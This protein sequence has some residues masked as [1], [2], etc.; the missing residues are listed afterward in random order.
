MNPSPTEA[1]QN[2]HLD[3]QGTHQ[4][5]S[6]WAAVVSWLDFSR[7]CLKWGRELP[8]SLNVRSFLVLW[9]NFNLKNIYEFHHCETYR[10]PPNWWISASLTPLVTNG[11]E[12]TIRGSP[13]KV[14]GLPIFPDQDRCITFPKFSKMGLRR[15]TRNRL[16]VLVS[17]M[18]RS[19]KSSV[20]NQKKIALEF[21]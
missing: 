13:L 20:N 6:E 12:Q 4:T 19:N 7:T 3:S 10:N 9:D 8:P 2:Y 11:M 5:P 17:H 16:R 21:L 1:A 14:I 18:K 15:K